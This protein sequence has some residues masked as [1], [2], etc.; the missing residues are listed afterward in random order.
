MATDAAGRGMIDRM[1][2]SPRSAAVV[3][4]GLLATACAEAQWQKPG[5][6][7]A[8][9]DSD[10]EQC[11]REARLQARQQELPRQD[12]PLAIRADPQGRPVVVP[13][14]TRQSDR[15]IAE[16]DLTGACMRQKG[17]ALTPDRR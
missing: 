10:L 12:A 2:V 15:F 13:N 17:Y 11:R 16:Q 8:T 9:R 6:D 1:R 3:L 4:L 14:T 5:A 7:A